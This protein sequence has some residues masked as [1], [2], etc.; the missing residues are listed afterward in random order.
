MCGAVAVVVVL[1]AEEG[2]MLACVLN[3]GSK[4]M[5]GIN[6][7]NSGIHTLALDTCTVGDDNVVV[8]NDVVDADGGDNDM[9]E[10]TVGSA[11]H[12]T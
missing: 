2:E 3:K 11:P 4:E 12:T 7:C 10:E 5:L 1:D 8:V 6:N 9:R